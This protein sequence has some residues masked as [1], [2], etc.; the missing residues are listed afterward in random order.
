MNNVSPNAEA[1]PARTHHLV[2]PSELPGNL[3]DSRYR[4]TGEAEGI[5]LR[6]GHPVV[7]LHPRLRLLDLH[8]LPL[9][10]HI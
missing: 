2:R 5:L 8:C 4:S 7:R 6:L 1:P 3:T 9:R 10:A